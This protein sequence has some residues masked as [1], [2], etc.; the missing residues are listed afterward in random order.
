MLSFAT[1]AANSSTSPAWNGAV[2][3]FE[4]EGAVAVPVTVEGAG[5]TE[6]SIFAETGE[7]A[8]TGAGRNALETRAGDPTLDSQ[9]SAPAAQIS[10][11]STAIVAVSLVMLF[12]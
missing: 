7:A 10:A 1:S 6:L 9:Y 8:E 3:S 11:A 4:G 5:S 12:V 2:A